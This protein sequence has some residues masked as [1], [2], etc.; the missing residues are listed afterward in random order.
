MY[1]YDINKYHFKHLINMQFYLLLDKI[2]EQCF[3]PFSCDFFFSPS[4]A[5]LWYGF[6]VI[7][8][9]SSGADKAKTVN[10]P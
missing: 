9:V 6:I 10:F 2:V 7:L 3:Q 8:L 5:I 1:Y 4:A